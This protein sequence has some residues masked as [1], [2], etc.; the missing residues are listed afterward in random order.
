MEKACHRNGLSRQTAVAADVA[1]EDGHA[2]SADGKREER[3][4]HGGIDRIAE[5]AHL[6]RRRASREEAREVR[7]QVEGE[8]LG[9]VGEQDAVDGEDDDGHEEACHHDLRDALHAFLQAHAADAE[10]D[11]ADKK[12]PAEHLQGIGLKRREDAAGVFGGDTVEV[13]RPHLEGVGHHPACD[14]GVKHHEDVVAGDGEPLI[15][16]P[17]RSFRFQDV[18][19]SRAAFLRRVAHRKLHDQ[20]GD[21]Q[22]DKE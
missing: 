2:R 5:R 7:E 13:S 15:E 4:A 11:K 12:Q 18:E 8:T 1:A 14:G 10:A 16:M 3:L 20:D 17:L 22:D 9:R 19:A 21:A 6:L